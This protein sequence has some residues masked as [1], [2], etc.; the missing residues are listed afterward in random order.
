MLNLLAATTTANKGQV[1]THKA[2]K[3]LIIS[4]LSPSSFLA[5]T[6]SLAL[7][8]VWVLHQNLAC[9]VVYLESL[10]KMLHAVDHLSWYML[11]H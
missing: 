6:F 4:L 8:W 9:L 10:K 1:I 7:A 3:F 2:I 11:N 5:L